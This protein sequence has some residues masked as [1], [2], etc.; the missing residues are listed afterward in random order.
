V[1]ATLGSRRRERT[2]ALP[3]PEFLSPG[4]H[5]YRFR[6]QGT[7]VLPDMLLNAGG[8]TVSYFEWLKNLQ[9]RAQPSV[10]VGRDA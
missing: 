4:P 1:R 5:R 8:V 7:V 3:S 10:G 6:L 9:V 2:R